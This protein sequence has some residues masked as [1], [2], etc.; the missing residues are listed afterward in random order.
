MKKL[1]IGGSTKIPKVGKVK[2]N[3]IGH[4]QSTTQSI[5]QTT[6]PISL[7]GFEARAGEFLQ[8]YS[9][10]HKI[11]PPE[12][13]GNDNVGIKYTQI[14]DA[15]KDLKT[16]TE[17]GTI[18]N[19]DNAYEKLK[20]LK[21]IA[22]TETHTAETGI[23][24]YLKDKADG[25]IQ[26]NTEKATYNSNIKLLTAY[27][28]HNAIEAKNKLILTPEEHRLKFLENTAQRG[29]FETQA[30][31]LGGIT[32]I[33]YLTRKAVEIGSGTKTDRLGQTFEGYGRNLGRRL[34]SF[35][36][37]S[38]SHKSA[39]TY[40]NRLFKNSESFKATQ[41]KIDTTL[42]K[43]N[44]LKKKL[45]ADSG[46][47]N[48]VSKRK[49]MFYETQIQQQGALLNR[50][51]KQA[52]WW[53]TQITDTKTQLTT[54]QTRIKNN[55]N[56]AKKITKITN[57]KS[58]SPQQID[59][60]KQF[61][62]NKQYS[63]DNPTDISSKLDKVDYFFKDL[64]SNK[65][66]HEAV[67]VN[68]KNL[69]D[70]YEPI[71]TQRKKII[72]SIEVQNKIIEDTNSPAADK[73]AAMLQKNELETITGKLQDNLNIIK[74]HY[75]QLKDLEKSTLKV[76]EIENRIKTAD[77]YIK[78]ANQYTTGNNTPRRKVFTQGN[79][80]TQ[81]GFTPTAKKLFQQFVPNVRPVAD[82]I[83]S[84]VD[85]QKEIARRKSLKQ[86]KINNN[87]SKSL[88]DNQK[89]AN[90]GITLGTNITPEAAIE[91][92]KKDI[93]TIKRDKLFSSNNDASFN[94][95][96]QLN[97][98]AKI[99]PA[100]FVGIVNKIKVDVNENKFNTVDEIIDE[101]RSLF[102]QSYKKDNVKTSIGTSVI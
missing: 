80:T 20:N 59:N 2:T 101:I 35:G 58:V 88:F 4:K 61:V 36:W 49:Q 46:K 39:G 82:S 15:T 69:K 10:L 47:L 65:I 29:F 13:H 78:N 81:K 60:V 43:I 102:T 45:E 48:S 24:K 77:E 30:A 98:L 31:R 12:T 6:S 71:L 41:G 16:A 22:I 54:K 89:I 28:A 76:S 9:P 53:K 95:I 8:K 91:L 3:N 83:A 85:I 33:N 79:I 56:L 92:L 26:N 68:I 67:I 44:N 74:S 86:K 27:K 96:G 72:D 34:T 93:P 18:K 38:G 90:L 75:S 5:G 62:M 37:G 50:Y 66:T 84:S 40:A 42:S 52:D 19:K 70:I 63:I 17:S 21:I 23:D 87:L 73:L 25:I 64:H 99:N 1:Y 32:G 11:S 51:N 57:T 100:L 97:T 14:A 55:S 94:K 7:A